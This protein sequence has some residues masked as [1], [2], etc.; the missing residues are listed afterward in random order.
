VNIINGKEKKLKKIKKFKIMKTLSKA[1]AAILVTGCS[2]MMNIGTA[3]AK[4]PLFNRFAKY[5][6]E[7]GNETFSVSVQQVGSSQVMRVSI[8][9]PE[10]KR[11]VVTLKDADGNA[12]YSA[13]TDRDKSRIQTDY[14]FSEAEQGKYTL[15]V[16]DGKTKVKK[17]IILERIKVQEVTHL[18]VN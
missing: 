7:I 18:S 12:I 15:E 6:I 8:E 5:G 13:L 17:Q 16:S 3:S 14:N 1:I 10:G 9:K 2:L 4:S 11:L